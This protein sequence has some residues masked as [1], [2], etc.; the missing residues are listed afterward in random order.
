MPPTSDAQ[1]DARGEE[2][3][4]SDEEPFPILTS[5]KPS[6]EVPARG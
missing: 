3:A 6:P 1:L 5:E 4:L 2:A